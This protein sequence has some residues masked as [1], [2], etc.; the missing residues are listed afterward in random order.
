MKLFPDGFRGL[1]PP[2]VEVA[3]L[4]IV[5]ETVGIVG[6]NEPSPRVPAVGNAL[7][8]GTGGAEPTPRLPISVDPN[9]I[10]VRAPPPGVVGDVDV[11]VEDD[12]MLPEP[13]IPDIPEV[14]SIPGRR[15]SRRH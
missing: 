2:L 14:S 7:G 15:H 5:G 6:I 12:A 1:I 10:P 13:H 8:S 11:G 4:P 3:A 9:G